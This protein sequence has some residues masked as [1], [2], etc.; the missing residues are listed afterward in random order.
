MSVFM[1]VPHILMTADILSILLSVKYDVSSF[2]LS[3]D[4]FGYLRSF[5]V[6]YETV[7]K[8]RSN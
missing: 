8:K 2:V 5:V 6:S 1:L 3:Q 4:C 7:G